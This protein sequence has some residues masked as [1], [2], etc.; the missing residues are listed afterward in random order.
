M[1]NDNDSIPWFIYISE[2]TIIVTFLI[3]ASNTLQLHF[4]Y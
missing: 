2:I 4:D 3:S 1:T